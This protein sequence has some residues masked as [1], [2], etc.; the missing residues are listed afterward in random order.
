ML[1]MDYRGFLMARQPLVG[2]GLFIVEVSRSHSDTPHS[3]RLAW[4]RDWPVAETCT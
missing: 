3:V 1:R 2:F 4:W